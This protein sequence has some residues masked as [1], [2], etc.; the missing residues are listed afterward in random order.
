[1]G[2]KLE[3][4]TIAILGASSM[5]SHRISTGM[6]ASGGVSL[7]NSITRCEAAAAAGRTANQTPQPIPN[8]AASRKPAVVRIA[9]MPM[10]A[11][12]EPSAAMRANDAHT[13]SGAGSSTGEMPP[14]CA[15]SHHAARSAAGMTRLKSR[16][17]D[18]CMFM[19]TVPSTGD[20]QHR[21][22]IPE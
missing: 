15:A 9:L 11:A 7:R 10:C 2:K 20:R 3:R 1:M 22:E 14:L 12:S 8:A 19:R 13:A 17:R 18:R 6:S 16:S 5:P 21:A 4:K